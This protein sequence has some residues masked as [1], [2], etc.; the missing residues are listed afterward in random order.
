MIAYLVLSAPLRKM[1]VRRVETYTE[2]PDLR[3]GILA[4][5]EELGDDE[6][7]VRSTLLRVEKQYRLKGM[8]DV[9]LSMLE[10]ERVS[11][12]DWQLIP[13]RSKKKKKT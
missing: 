3:L 13:R 7:A 9:L 4:I 1:V 6:A 10:G 12:S 11:V 8:A 5:L 2:D